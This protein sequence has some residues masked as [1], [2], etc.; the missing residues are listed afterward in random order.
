M[1]VFRGMD[2]VNHIEWK[3][4]GRRKKGTS[5]GKT[6]LRKDKHRHLQGVARKA[7]TQSGHPEK[8][9][10]KNSLVPSDESQDSKPEKNQ[11]N[12]GKNQDPSI[13]D[14]KCR[15]GIIHGESHLEK[16]LFQ[17]AMISLFIAPSPFVSYS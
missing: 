4:P 8:T 11:R 17:N 13:G 3:I 15:F 16:S 12:A 9:G 5:I 7:E 1:I 14:S 6:L 2:R 10:G